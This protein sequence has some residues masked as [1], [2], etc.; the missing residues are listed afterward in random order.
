MAAK[1][2]TLLERTFTLGDTSAQN[3]VGDNFEE[4]VDKM[5][6]NG[7]GKIPNVP[8]TID[9]DNYNYFRRVNSHKVGAGG[10]ISKLDNGNKQGSEIFSEIILKPSLLISDFDKEDSVRTRRSGVLMPRKL[11]CMSSITMPPDNVPNNLDS[12]SRPD[13]PSGGDATSD[14]TKEDRCEL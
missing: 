11:S 8:N 6:N 12:P 13:S 9:Q 3:R 1:Q 5:M 14:K 2:A 7:K 4:Q 10:T